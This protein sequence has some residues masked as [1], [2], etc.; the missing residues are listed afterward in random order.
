MKIKG[1]W[2]RTVDREEW[3]PVIKEAKALRGPY[4]QGA[5]KYVSK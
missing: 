4:S 2:Q 1:Q 5:S 3:V